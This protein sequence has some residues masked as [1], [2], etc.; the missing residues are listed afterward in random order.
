MAAVEKIEAGVVELRTDVGR[1]YVCPSSW[2][3]AY[4]RWTF[5]NFHTLPRQV[6]NERQRRLIETL[7]RTAIVSA[8]AIPP[9]AIIGVV[10]GVH[11]LGVPAHAEIA[12]AKAPKLAPVNLKARMVE[13]SAELFD[14]ELVGSKPERS[15][16][17]ERPQLP[18]TAGHE[19]ERLNIELEEGSTR[20]RAQKIIAA[21][22]KRR[23]WL[24]PVLGAVAAAVLV[25]GIEALPL[26]RLPQVPRARMVAP[27]P[28]P[29]AVQQSK[30]P[31][32][33]PV[34]VRR[35]E[36]ASSNT[37][38]S[39]Q[40]LPGRES[41]VA[42]G[43]VAEKAHAK[44]AVRAA[45]GSPVSDSIALP[46]IAEAPQAGFVYPV[47]PNPNLV[48]KVLLKAVIGSDGAVKQVEVLSGD[49]AL[50]AAAARAVRHWRYA[51]A[52]VDGRAVD[53]QTNVMV[54]FL[55]DDAVSISLPPAR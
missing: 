48:G 52:Q 2:Q 50:G 26:W 1:L 22:S 13:A 43:R 4:L 25:L 29:Q 39:P 7:S 24:V 28:P 42:P 33:P 12:E 54:S 11:V 8:E 15:D 47:A 20:L 36:L 18:S 40:A 49:R 14:L 27:A 46:Q 19:L 37:P 38:A 9:S 55:G 5:R 51:P 10:E 3:R 44:P 45:A 41:Q 6:L 34:V 23:P 21:G 32:E 31:A 17:S 16:F 30:L 53:A 35:T